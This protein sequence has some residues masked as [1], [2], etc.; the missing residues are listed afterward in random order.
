MH[1]RI[2][3]LQLRL[4]R[5]RRVRL[6][7]R[8]RQFKLMSRHPYA[9]AVITFSALIVLSVGVYLLARQ[10]NHLPPV[11]DAKIVI[12]SH[13]HQQQIVP[14]REATVGALL[15]KLHLQLNQGDVVE[16]AAT[17]IIDQDQF[18][19][20]I[21]RAVPVEIIDGSQRSFTFS[22][23]TTP[24]AVAEQ[25]GETVYPED[26]ISSTPTQNFL[27]GQAIGEQVVINRATP[28]NLNLY[29]TPLV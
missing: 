16:P 4:A 26:T 12:I 18:R 22:A 19:I 5:Y 2:Q 24:R 25:A 21:Y 1:K 7:H 27:T 9:A 28:V 8:I 6:P 3:T 23:A 29:G 14:T 20:N 17:T 15:K 11:Q 10:T 13:D